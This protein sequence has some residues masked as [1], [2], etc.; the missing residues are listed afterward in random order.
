MRS[1][2]SFT[3][4]PRPTG[5]WATSLRLTFARKRSAADVGFD[6]AG[7]DGVDRDTVRP[8][9]TGQRPCEPELRG[10]RRRVCNGTEYSA[11]PLG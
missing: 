2:T 3:L 6:E 9:F 5:I 7:S 1:A 4:P 10:L 8:Q 11:A